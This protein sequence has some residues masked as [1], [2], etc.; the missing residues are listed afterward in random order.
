MVRGCELTLPLADTVIDKLSKYA[1]Q[2]VEFTTSVAYI[3]I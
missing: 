1:I 3:C 2:G